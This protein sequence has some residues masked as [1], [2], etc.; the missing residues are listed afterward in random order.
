MSFIVFW[1]IAS[2]IVWVVLQLA[3]GYARA[4]GRPADMSPKPGKTA[5]ISALIGLL[6]ALVLVGILSLGK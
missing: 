3:D 4:N 1:G 5:V 6:C 2:A